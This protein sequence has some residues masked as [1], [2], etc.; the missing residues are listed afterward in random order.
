MEFKAEVRDIGGTGVGTSVYI[1]DRIEPVMAWLAMTLKE[2][3]AGSWTLTGP[4]VDMSG[5]PHA[6]LP[7]LDDQE[8]EVG[9]E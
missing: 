1:R 4:G 9:D 3:W 7:E 5:D 2:K 8:E 6:P